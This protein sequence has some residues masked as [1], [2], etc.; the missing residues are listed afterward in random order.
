MKNEDKLLKKW[1]K[2]YK[3]NTILV[4][5]KEGNKFRVEKTDPRYLSGEL[6]NGY[7]WRWMNL[8]EE[9]KE[10]RNKKIREKV[11][12]S[13]R[14]RKEKSEADTKTCTLNTLEQ[15][16]TELQN[17]F[18]DD[19]CLFIKDVIAQGAICKEDIEFPD[20]TILNTWIY[21]IKS[22][23]RAHHFSAIR[24]KDI[25]DV[26]WRRLNRKHSKIKFMVIK[27]NWWGTGRESIAAFNV[28]DGEKDSYD[29]L[30]D[31]AK[32]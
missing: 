25:H 28:Q 21:T 31:W 26:I 22:A 7:K 13:W 19:E 5:D 23:K 6:V 9:E 1:L 3:S 4:R 15:F 18:N 24:M 17:C 8:S 12:D 10:A 11:S 29:I 32:S 27:R 16:I 2:L 20:G 14:L 30:M